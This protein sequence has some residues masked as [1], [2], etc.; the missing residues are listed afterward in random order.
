MIQIKTSKFQFAHG[1][2]PSGVGYWAFIFDGTSE[3]WFAEIG[4]TIGLFNWPTA[5]RAARAEAKRR[6]ASSIELQP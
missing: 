5:K 4:N 3:P 6:N 1:G 2:L